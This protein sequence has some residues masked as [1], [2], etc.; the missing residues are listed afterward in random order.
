MILLAGIIEGLT[1]RKDK[2][3]KLSIGTNELT[4]QEAADLFSL[5][6][7]FCYIAIK[8]EPFVKM[9]YDLI[10]ELKTDYENA[11]TPSQRLRAILYR[12]YEKDSEG[13]KDFQTYY[14]KKMDKI[15]EHYKGKLDAESY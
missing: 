7:Q 9:E 1:T 4:P 13:F 11:K 2:T 5:N 6:S 8:P 15:C 3:I 14:Y 10:Q 12:N